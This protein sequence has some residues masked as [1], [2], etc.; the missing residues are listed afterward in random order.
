ME[1]AERDLRGS[2][3]VEALALHEVDVRVVRGEPAG[4]DERFLAHE[5]RREDRHESLGHE[6]V[7]REPVERERDEGG[8]PDPEPEPRAGDARRP[9]H[10]EAA[11]LRVLPRLVERG[12]IR[13]APHLHGLFLGRSVRHRVGRRVRDEHGQAIALALRLGELGLALFQLLLHSLERLELLGRRLPLELRPRA[14]LV[15]LGDERAPALVR[16]EER[17]ERLRGTLSRERGAVGVG[18]GA[19]RLQVDHK[20]E[21]RAALAAGDVRGDVRD[22]LL[23]ELLP[24]CRH[25]ALAVRHAID[26]KLE[27]R[28]GVVEVRP[29][30]AGRTGI[31]KRVARA[32][33]TCADEDGLAGGGIAFASPARVGRLGVG[34]LG[35]GLGLL[36]VVVISPVVVSGSGE[37]SSSP[38]Q[39]A[40]P[41]AKTRA[42]SASA[43]RRIRA[44]D[45]IHAEPLLGRLPG[46]PRRETTRLLLGEPARIRTIAVR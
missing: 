21:S 8:V 37:A 44:S 9:L 10:V 38:P 22:L 20:L 6:P 17:V 26:G 30:R 16:R 14:E 32:A 40:R 1:T 31:G 43:V 3:E 15:D 13:A 4:A 35:L 46:R 34:R 27:A 24:E 28:L 45:P 25:R 23:G 18:I 2:R 5:H 42:T 36:S 11:D 12:R 33:A 41:K 39:A 29:D 7:E 19:S